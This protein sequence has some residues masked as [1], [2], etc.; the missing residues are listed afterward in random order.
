MQWVGVVVI[1]DDVE[2]VHLETVG[3]DALSR[4]LCRVLDEFVDLAAVF[5]RHLVDQVQFLLLRSL[6][7]VHDLLYTLYDVM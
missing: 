4:P 2:G 7:V 1:V 5:V 6:I 3:H